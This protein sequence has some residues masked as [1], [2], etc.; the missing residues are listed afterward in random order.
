MS[1]GIFIDR[2]RRVSKSGPLILHGRSGIVEKCTDENTL[3]VG[4]L[5]SESVDSDFRSQV[6]ERDRLPYCS[7][8]RTAA[9]HSK[10]DLAV[11][12][13]DDSDV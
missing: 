4:E 2:Q 13:T 12:A 11:R 1:I 7:Q 3:E 8:A 9:I 10:A 5:S 6:S